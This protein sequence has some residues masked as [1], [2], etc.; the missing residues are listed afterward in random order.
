VEAAPLVAV[1]QPESRVA[2][3]LGAALRGAMSHPLAQ[4][5]KSPPAL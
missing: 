1:A 4:E 5:E 2:S 3:L